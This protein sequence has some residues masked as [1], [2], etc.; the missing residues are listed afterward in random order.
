[1]GSTKDGMS[2]TTFLDV[3]K[4]VHS[5]SGLIS[6]SILCTMTTLQ[7]DM[8]V[9]MLWETFDMV[10]QAFGEDTSSR[11]QGFQWHKR[12][13]E[14]RDDVRDDGRLSKSNTDD[15]DDRRRMSAS[16]PRLLLLSWHPSNCRRG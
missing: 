7:W 8:K 12:F 4:V 16:S 3:L 15:N 10:S 6:K 9:K 2:K 1:M 11:T 5:K 13:Q 14:G